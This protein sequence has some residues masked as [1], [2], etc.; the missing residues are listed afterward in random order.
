MIPLVLYDHR[1][2]NTRLFFEGRTYIISVGIAVGG[3]RGLFTQ[4]RRLSLSE[5]TTSYTD[6]TK[7]PRWACVEVHIQTTRVKKQSA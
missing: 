4:E 3:R 1:P 2:T 7:S 5:C 6:L